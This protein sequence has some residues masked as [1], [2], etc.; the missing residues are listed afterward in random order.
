MRTAFLAERLQLTLTDPL[1]RPQP[2]R[3]GVDFLGYIVRPDYVLVRQ[4]VVSRLKA[5]LRDYEQQLVRP[6][7][8]RT[9]F[10]HDAATLAQL[11][12]TRASYRAHLTMASSHRLR[13]SLVSQCGWV[14]HFFVLEEGLLVPRATVPPAFA[15][16]K[17]QYVF[18]AERW[19]ESVLLFQVG[20]LYEW[21]DEQAE[22]MIGLM[23]LRPLV[24]RRGFRV[25]CGVPVRLGARCVRALVAQGVSV[26]VTRERKDCPWLGGVKPRVLAVVWQPVAM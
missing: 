5:R 21:Y 9:V 13:E 20:R 4:R 23:G 7:S 16:L 17:D 18:F 3:N 14:R 25:R 1:A 12:A 2:I 15:R 22:Q 24:H 11:R 26:A 19:P 8:E 6:R 10:R